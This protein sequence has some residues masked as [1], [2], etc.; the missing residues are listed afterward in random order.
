MLTRQYDKI[1]VNASGFSRRD[2]FVIRRRET[3]F[4]VVVFQSIPDV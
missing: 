1:V 4:E 3:C 2:A